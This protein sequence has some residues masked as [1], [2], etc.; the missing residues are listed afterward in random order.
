MH[1]KDKLDLDAAALALPAQLGNDHAS[2]RQLIKAAK[3]YQGPVQF[4]FEATGPYIWGL[5]LL[6]GTCSRAI[7][8][9]LSDNDIRCG[10]SDRR[11]FPARPALHVHRR[12]NNGKGPIQNDK[13]AGRDVQR[14][15][16]RS[17]ST[18]QS[19]ARNTAVGRLTAA[20]RG[21]ASL[22]APQVRKRFETCNAGR[23]AQ[24]IGHPRRCTG[25]DRRTPGG[26]SRRSASLP[27]SAKWLGPIT[28]AGD[29]CRDVSQY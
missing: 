19:A 2:F 24:R 20:P 21:S 15:T 12:R 17:A 22:P 1:Y 14:R 27:A 16:R 23:A 7:R 8:R 28:P 3:K 18:I 4:V 10:G 5:A 6:V 9:R 29:D 11:W 26:G 13:M 25:H